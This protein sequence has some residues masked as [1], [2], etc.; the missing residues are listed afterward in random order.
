MKITVG[1][2]TTDDRQE[3]ATLYRGYA[4]FYQVPIIS[5]ILDT[6]WNWIFEEDFGFNALVAKNGNN[7]PIDLMHF[8]EM[9]SPLRGKRL[10]F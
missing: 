7:Y 9:S 3:W 2:L 5:E 1:A 4:E 6:V 10:V 8:R